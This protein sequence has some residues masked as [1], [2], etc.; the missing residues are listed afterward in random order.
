MND[1]SPDAAIEMIPLSD[2][3]L[4]NL[5][6]RA[7]V[8]D[9]E[10]EAMADSIQVSGLLQNLIGYRTESGRIDIVGGGKRLRALQLLKSGRGWKKSQIVRVIDPVPVKITDNPAIAVQWSGTENTARSD[11]HP[12]DEVRAYARMRDQGNSVPM[13]ART[14]AKSELHVDRRLKLADLPADA[15][16]ALRGDRITIDVARALTLAPTPEAATQALDIATQPRTTAAEIR[17]MFTS[18]HVR[19]DDRRVVFVGLNHYIDA[20]GTADTDLFEGASYLHDEK[21][22]DRLFK[23][24]LQVKAELIKVADGWSW[25]EFTTERYLDY[26]KM[27]KFDR[28]HREPVELTDADQAE[29]D[30]IEARIDAVEASTADH[31]RAEELRQRMLG[32]YSDD[33]IA[34]GGIF[35]YVDGHGE[36]QRSAAYRRAGLVSDDATSSG[37]DGV[38]IDRSTATPA[39]DMP[40]NLLDDLARI[41]LAALQSAAIDK[42]ELMLDLL[43]FSFSPEVSVYGRPLNVR[44]DTPYITPDKIDG[45]TIDARLVQDS[46]RAADPATATAFEAF[47]A[48]GKKHRNAVLS[49][50]LARHLQLDTRGL[51][52]ALAKEVGAQIRRTWTP[53]AAGFLSR[54]APAY[55]DRLWANLL[56]LDLGDEQRET[57]GK[58]KKA[59]KAKALDGLFNDMSVRE[60][61][62]L[63][64]EQNSRIDAWVPAELR[65]GTSEAR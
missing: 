22:L 37:G 51:S 25:V 7:D 54:C 26:S 52:D 19:S 63:T 39:P 50:T 35:I 15:L 10:V 27:A 3:A 49:C 32:D 29:F 47:R 1:L 64:R 13:I 12:A 16:D 40:Q 31:E 2:L 60:A 61:H 36:L 56:D 55:L 21:L 41:K 53:T 6:A 44:L 46:A 59:D 38:T 17:R 8:S 11:L 9:A 45:T 23:D 18:D 14:F 43:A 5:N 48:K 34:H 4:S 20:G 33:D 42:T 62:G 30:A 58:L 24:A 57:F 65:F 28:I